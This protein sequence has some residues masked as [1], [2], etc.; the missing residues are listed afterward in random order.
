MSSA[1][2]QCAGQARMP[3]AAVQGRTL[4]QYAA[5]DAGQRG[6]AARNPARRLAEFVA[7]LRLADVP[8]PVRARGLEL[9]L[10]A[11]G[12]GLAAR[13]TEFAERTIAGAIALGGY[14]TSTVIGRPQGLTL[15]DAALVNGVLLHGLDFDDTHL[16]AI[17]HP[18]VACLP[19]AFGVAEA[20]HAR[21]ADMLAAYIAGMECAIRIGA[22]AQGGFHHVGFHATGIVSHFASALVAGRLLGLDPDALVSAQGIAASTASGVQV[23]LEEGAWTKRLHPGWGAV[24]GITAAS[25]ARSGFFGPSRPFNGRFGLF[26][27][28]L[29]QG[30]DA[31]DL[32]HMTNGLGRDWQLAQTSIKP[33]PVCH[34]LHG[35]A[36]AAIRLHGA[37]HPSVSDLLEIRVRIPGDT[38]TVVAE[39]AERKCAP[40]NDY[41]AKFSA[42]YVVAICLLKGRMGLA[43]LGAEARNDPQVRSLAR[44]IVVAADPLSAFP[45][46]M[47]GGVSVATRDGRS[48]DAY[49]PINSGSGPRAMQRASVSDKFFASAE[50]SIPYAHAARIRQA[51]LGLEGIAV[52]EL[53]DVVRVA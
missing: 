29:Q 23:F 9:M 15:R 37:L 11:V 33:Y 39:P 30:A 20:A 46:Y 22:A 34:F 3:D 10:D 28:H 51:I 27:T 41:D 49:V 31:I 14:G 4:L 18:T 13:A 48:H 35:A 42:Q 5:F 45:Q 8:E 52:A 32:A 7:G 26:E 12:V 25:L 2:N 53:A 36:E 24:A 40:G 50:L 17:V 1:V 47:S 38:L 19:T 43:E 6:D 21:G 44:R 16:G